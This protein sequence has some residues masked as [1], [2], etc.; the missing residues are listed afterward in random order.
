MDNMSYRMLPNIPTIFIFI[1][2]LIC[3]FSLYPSIALDPKITL[4]RS[5]SSEEPELHSSGVSAVTNNTNLQ[6]YIVHVKL[7]YDKPNSLPFHEL[8]SLYC[9]F[10]PPTIPY[11]QRQ[12]R[13]V[14]CYR[15][16][17]TGFAA[18]L[19]LEEV[20]S[21]AKKEGILSATPEKFFSLH[22][23][24]SPTFMGLQ[25]NTGLWRDA[26]YGRGMIIG[27]LDSGVT[28]NHPSFSDT[29]VPTPPTRW[30][31]R[32]DLPSTACNNKLIGARTAFAG[33]TPEDTNGHGT[34]VASIAAGN[35]VNGANVFA[36]ASGTAS[37]IAPLAHLAIYKVC[38]Q[39]ATGFSCPENA[40]LAGIDL[41]ID[42]G[43]DVLSISAGFRPSPFYSDP[44]AV[45]A[46]AA[47]QRGIFVSCAIGNSGP[48]RASLSNQ[49]PWLLSVGA[50]SIN[51]NIRATAV[52][53]NGV[54]INGES[55]LQYG[56][57]PPTLLP[58][59]YL[60]GSTG[61]QEAAWCYRQWFTNINVRGMVVLCDDGGTIGLVE[62]GQNVR[63]AG[64]L[65]MI[66]VNQQIN[67]DTIPAEDAHVLPATHVGYRDGTTIKTYISSTPSPQATILFR[68]T[69]YGVDYAPEV[70]SFSSRGPNTISP[71]ILKPDI[72]GPGSNILAAWPFSVD[73]TTTR[74][75]FNILS[76]TSMACPHLSGTAALLKTLHPSWSPAAIKSA[77]MTTAS[78]LNGNG[79]PITDQNRLEANWF[80][81][82]AGHVDPSSANNPG[83]VYDIQPDDY[84]PY[85]CGLGYTNQQVSIILHRTVSCSSAIPE[86]Q[87]NYPTFS[88]TLPS[89]SQTYT[90]T[91]TNVGDATSTYNVIVNLPSS[92]SAVV[93]PSRLDFT[94]VN[95]QLT[96]S[97]TFTRLTSTG[98]ALVRGYLTWTSSRHVVR[99]QISVTLT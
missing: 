47:I 41:A 86:A 93:T 91:V 11:S 88:I 87:L 32:C 20:K 23:T 17:I 79:I 81:L 54:Q 64:G 42:D 36:Q 50:S 26:N 51:R 5:D 56:N 72:I 35:F 43:V 75:T 77:I 27:V 21:M 99:S 55:L 69:V 65:A 8:E 67:G 1:L 94:R 19:S 24:H 82:G 44:I 66:L 37:G 25:Q 76:G 58:L 31:G 2:S 74:A 70:A 53:G 80:D 48:T 45:G 28:P 73:G 49:A 40:M 4:P 14:H 63:D 30:R 85:L 29:G 60:G 12:T 90:R 62:K 18:R 96:Y 6:T 15:H 92:V 89:G 39:T 10:L 3:M 33:D 61:I 57:F 84:I 9:S 34:H 46:F 71:G 59:V 97:V 16:V 38:Q 52:L 95:Q 13:M 83:L 98:P 68:G 22:T 78:V 7:P